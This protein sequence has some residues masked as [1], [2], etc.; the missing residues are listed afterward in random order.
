MSEPPPA[1]LTRK[2]AQATIMNRP[3]LHLVLSQSRNAL[4]R[5]NS[6]RCNG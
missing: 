3:R 2:V 4:P 5:L 1:K 6:Y